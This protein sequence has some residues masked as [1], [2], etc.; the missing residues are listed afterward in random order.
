MIIG[1]LVGAYI[2]AL[3]GTLIGLLLGATTRTRPYR[4]EGVLV[5][6][7]TRGFAALHRKMGF[8]AITLGHVIIVNEPPEY[9]LWAHELVHVRQWEILGPLMLVV[10]PLASIAGYRRNPFETYARRRTGT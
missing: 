8:K 3:P 5:F 4:R 6:E 10:Y 7:S 2:W 9:P 1:W